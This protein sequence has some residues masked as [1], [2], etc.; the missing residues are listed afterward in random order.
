MKMLVFFVVSA[1]V[2]PAKGPTISAAMKIAAISRPME[3]HL[4]SLESDDASRAAD[5]FGSV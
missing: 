4:S 3:S 2:E 5:W 1:K